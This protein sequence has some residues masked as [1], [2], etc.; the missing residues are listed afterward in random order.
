VIFVRNAFLKKCSF[1]LFSFR[2]S[3]WLPDVPTWPTIDDVVEDL[4]SS[5]PGCRLSSV[6]RPPIN[7][8]LLSTSF[9]EM[10]DSTRFVVSQNTVRSRRSTGTLSASSPAASDEEEL[11]WQFD[12]PSRTDKG[13][14]A[15]TSKLVG[16]G[17]DR[18]KSTLTNGFGSTSRRPPPKDLTSSSTATGVA[19]GAVTTTAT[20]DIWL[21]LRPLFL[22]ID[23]LLLLFH[24]TR[25]YWG[26]RRIL[27]HGDYDEDGDD[28]V[29]KEDDPNSDLRPRPS[30]VIVR[31]GGSGGNGVRLPASAIAV[32]LDRSSTTIVTTTER[33]IVADWT[34]E[35]CSQHRAG[36]GVTEYFHGVGGQ[37]ASLTMTSLGYSPLQRKPAIA[38]SYHLPSDVAAPNQSTPTGGATLSKATHPEKD[39]CCSSSAGVY[40]VRHILAACGRIVASRSVLSIL[41]FAA[42]L[43][44]LYV[45]LALTCRSSESEFGWN[46]RRD[47]SNGGSRSLA[48]GTTEAA[49]VVDRLVTSYVAVNRYHVAASNEYVY[50]EASYLY[51]AILGGCA[52]GVWNELLNLQTLIN[53]FNAG[54]CCR[55]TLSRG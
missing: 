20:V 10:F 46:W 32:N 8:T 41:G 37:P 15:P 36:T 27:R 23:S 40:A 19:I 28:D 52:G 50:E 45:A 33:L 18:R 38:N 4:S 12:V 48:S 53:N 49:S 13:D 29:E 39:K 9:R 22:V 16:S 43:T 1:G 24:L 17:H 35:M 42:L 25:A 7:V 55:C 31:N 6:D 21:S 26:C 2:Y 14:Y 44:S 5:T 3:R 34:V 47:Q 51:D 30:P 11:Y 54:R